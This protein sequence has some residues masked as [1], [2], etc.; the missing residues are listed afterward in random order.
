MFIDSI[1]GEV[2]LY[3][4]KKCLGPKEYSQMVHFGWAKVYSRILDAIVPL[5]VKFELE[6]REL[7]DQIQIKR[8]NQHNDPNRPLF[9][10][11]GEG[12]TVTR[13]GAATTRTAELV[14][15]K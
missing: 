13:E 14:E 11:R 9:T 5:V 2:L 1:M 15:K 3:T 12:A 8:N 6:N 4:I 7:A 10:I